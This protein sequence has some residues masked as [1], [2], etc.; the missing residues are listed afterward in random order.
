MIWFLIDGATHSDVHRLAVVVVQI[1][2]LWTRE[3][4]PIL[5]RIILIVWKGPTTLDTLSW[6]LGRISL[7]SHFGC[8]LDWD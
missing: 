5:W 4:A 1:T 3:S 2:A 7:L 8:G 6:S